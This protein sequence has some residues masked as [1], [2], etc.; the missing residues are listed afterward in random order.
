LRLLARRITIVGVF[1]EL[2]PKAKRSSYLSNLV[3]Y[4]A[5]RDRR[6]KS[7]GPRRLRHAAL[8]GGVSLFRNASESI[9]FL[10]EKHCLRERPRRR[11]SRCGWGPANGEYGC[12]IRRVPPRELASKRPRR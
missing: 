4:S 2:R 5:F 9:D 1:G 7:L 3:C 6:E 10:Q 11:L 12:E 8:Q